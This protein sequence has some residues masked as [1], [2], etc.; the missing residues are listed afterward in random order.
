MDVTFFESTPYFSETDI[1]GENSSSTEY[2]SVSLSQLE[3][4]LHL[5]L[6]HRQEQ[7]LEIPVH[8][9]GPDPKNSNLGQNT[10]NPN[11]SSSITEPDTEIPAAGANKK[12]FHVYSRRKPQQENTQTLIQQVQSHEPESEKIPPGN[13]VIDSSVGNDDNLDLPNVVRKGVRSCTT[14]HPIANFIS[15]ENLSPNYRVFIANMST[16]EIPKTWQEGF[17]KP[18]WRKA[19]DE[20]MNA[21]KKNKTLEMTSLPAEKQSVGC[22]WIFTVKHKANGSIDRYKARQRLYTNVWDRLP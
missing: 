8:I 7:N 6:P 15:Y 12:E 21:L 3:S 13:S 14:Q 18:E 2:Q 10:E 5:S 9:L 4:S 22:K 16:V 19:I 1:Q 11:S 20:E 17:K